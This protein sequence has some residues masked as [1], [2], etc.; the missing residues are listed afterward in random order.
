MKPAAPTASAPSLTMWSCCSTLIVPSRSLLTTITPWS[1]APQAC[2]A[3]KSS[4][5]AA[6]ER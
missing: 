6:L 5:A 1:G 2:T 4:S 3:S